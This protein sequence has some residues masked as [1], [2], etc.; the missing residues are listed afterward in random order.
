[1]A[2]NSLIVSAD[3]E[4]LEILAEVERELGIAAE[5]RA[6]AG[7]AI[8]AI[9][10]E[11]FDLAIFDCDLVA[12]VR[13]DDLLRALRVASL[14]A[15]VVIVA[16][17]SD[18]SAM[19]AT[20]EHGANFVLHK[21]LNA[22]VLRRT[23][24]AAVCVMHRSARRYPRREVDTLAMVE[25]DGERDQ[26]MLTQLGEGGIGLQ[27]LEQLQVRRPLHL[28]FQLPGTEIDV[29]A[30][31]EIAWA[32]AV[33]RVGV[34]FVELDPEVRAQVRAWV[35]ND[36]LSGAEQTALA[37]APAADPD[38][39]PLLLRQGF[40]RLLAATLDA[41]FVLAATIIFEALVLALIRSFPHALMAQATML[42]IPCLFWIVYQYLFLHGATPGA[43]LAR[44]L[45]V[46]IAKN[47]RVPWRWAATLTQAWQTPATE[48]AAI[49]IGPSR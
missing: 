1:M 14:N 48:A 19:Q 33:G 15:K 30:T 12:P 6:D 26:A 25:I 38:A 5:A 29:E 10:A 27:A 18:T 17:V 23:L 34:R 42:A 46:G 21:P 43:R 13:S 2:W 24:R 28:H 22:Q 8:N 37:T 47:A 32:D 20:F 7:R 49:T 36:A 41:S 44:Y 11:K 9:G 40:P 3:P 31:G 35:L 4:A 39:R 45:L 16:L